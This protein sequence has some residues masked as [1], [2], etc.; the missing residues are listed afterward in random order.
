VTAATGT[1]AAALPPEPVRAATVHAVVPPILSEESADFPF[2]PS[3][4]DD[5]E[6]VSYLG[7]QRRWVPF[8][9]ALSFAT[10]AVTLYFF[11]AQHVMLWPFFVVLGLNVV[12]SLVSLV[13]GQMKRR[14]SL[15]SHIL[16]LRQYERDIL[17]GGSANLPSVDVFLP[18]CGEPI[19]VLDNTYR[20]VAA[21][22][23]A[24]PL[25]VLVLDDAMRPEVQRVA[26]AWGFTYVSR[27]DPGV[28]K[29]AGNLRHGFER[30]DGDVIAV[31][32]A[33]FAPRPDYL[34]HLLPYFGEPLDDGMK[35]GL[36]QSPQV[37]DTEP[38]M[39]WVQRT[40][41]A[42]QELFYRWVQPSRDSVGAAICV[43]TNA[44]YLRDALVGAGGFAQIE[45]SEDVHTGVRMLAAGWRTRYVP[46]QLAKGLCPSDLQAFMNQQYRWC[47]GSMSLLRS[48]EFH[49]IP[50]TWRQRLCF[51]SG[52]LYYL[53]TS[54]NV[55]VM[56]LPSLVMAVFYAHAIEPRHYVPLVAPLWVWLVLMPTVMR[57]RWRIDVLRIQMVYSYCHALAVVHAFTGRTRGWVATGS[58]RS[59]SAVGTSVRRIALGWTLGITL[60]S[61]VAVG[62]DVAREGWGQMWALVAFLLVTGY[63]WLPLVWSLARAEGAP[64]WWPAARLRLRWASRPAIRRRLTEAAQPAH[65]AVV[66][67]RLPEQAS[68]A[69]DL[70]VRLPQHRA[71][72][73]RLAVDP[74][75]ERPLATGGELA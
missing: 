24:G 52:F 63:L 47:T 18:T 53:T 17:I 5:A 71:G 57:S 55:F 41:G 62:I 65:V 59:G 3:P 34:H 75:P 20:H 43:G 50:M 2:L 54:V 74:A 36:V 25:H 30:T 7:P 31:F 68:G 8:V 19:A 69:P 48:K 22:Q 42:T 67:V 37:F 27:P 16:L 10:T 70:V 60:A 39:G 12:A 35:V 11:A 61:F 29:K 38:D 32:D 9:S 46:L 14:V 56:H 6:L 49:R 4:P 26:E 73:H 13:S 66:D 21:M 44:L 33:D 64:A 58:V 72:Q 51:W 1:P 23:W 28:M 40:A 45:H 15:H